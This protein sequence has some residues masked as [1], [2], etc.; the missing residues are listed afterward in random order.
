MSL[1]KYDVVQIKIPFSTEEDR[2]NGHKTLNFNRLLEAELSGDYKE[3]PC[4]VIGKDSNLNKIVLAEVRTNRD[5]RF[6]SMLND[7]AEAGIKHESAILTDKHQLVYVDEDIS[8]SL[9]SLKCGHLSEKDIA[10]FEKSFMEI[11]YNQHIQPTNLDT[12]WSNFEPD[13]ELDFD[14]SEMVNKAFKILANN[15][16][17]HPLPLLLAGENITLE[18]TRDLLA[19]L[20]PYYSKTL[21]SNLRQMDFVQNF[22]K[23]TNSFMASN[24]K[25]RPPR[26]YKVLTNEIKPLYQ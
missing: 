14:H 10:R 16:N 20:Q 9:E 6:R 5:K 19:H 7:P 15:W 21:P 1:Q 22:L 18:E 4:I 24:K 8:Q 26:C 2:I 13:L 3:R 11:N 17:K 23:E 12:N 25:G